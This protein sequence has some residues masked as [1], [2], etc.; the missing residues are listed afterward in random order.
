MNEEF[1]SRKHACPECGGLSIRRSVRSGFIEN[2]FYRVIGLRPYRC[3]N[4]HFRFFD[5]RSA[6][7]RKESLG[8]SE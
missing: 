3:Q 7:G 8:D 4:C 6:S 2:V 1:E 5:R